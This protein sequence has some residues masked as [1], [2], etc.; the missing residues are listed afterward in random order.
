MSRVKR[1]KR[2]RSIVISILAWGILAYAG[3]S[4]AVV[5]VA[6]ARVSGAVAGQSLVFVDD[7]AKV[8]LAPPCLDDWLGKTPA[9]SRETVRE[10]NFGE[11]YG[12]K[13]RRFDCH[14]KADFKNELFEKM[15][16]SVGN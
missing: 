9:A 3:Y 8:Y 7:S 13:Y 4:I 16:G 12:R 5:I 10:T 1:V 11:A 15:R 14:G 6:Y 2:I